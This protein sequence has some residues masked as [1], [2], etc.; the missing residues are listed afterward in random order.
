LLRKATNWSQNVFWKHIESKKWYQY[1][2]Q[3]GIQYY[4]LACIS[5]NA[6]FGMSFG[7]ILKVKNGANTFNKMAFSLMALQMA[8][9]IMNFLV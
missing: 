7:N 6:N 9:S 3:N 2:Q 5:N 4:E 1:I 8:F